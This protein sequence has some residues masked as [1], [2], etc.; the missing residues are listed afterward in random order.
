MT[1]PDYYAVL[2]V[3]STATQSE[4]KRSYRRLVRLY[5]PDLNQQNQPPVDHQMK[6]LNEAYKV[7]GHSSR[8]AAY[9]EQRRLLREQEARRLRQQLE[10]QREPKMTWVEGVFGFIRE[11]KKGMRD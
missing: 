6:L 1:L 3:P 10:A 2:E 5:H 11:L 7:L 8:R 4:I 9:D